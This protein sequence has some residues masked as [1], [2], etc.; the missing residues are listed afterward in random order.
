MEQLKPRTPFLYAPHNKIATK[1]CDAQFKAAPD[2]EREHENRNTDYQ[3]AASRTVSMEP[4][5]RSPAFS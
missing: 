1:L 4:A 3:G 2:L 5:G